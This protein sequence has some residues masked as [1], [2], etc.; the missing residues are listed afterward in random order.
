MRSSLSDA[1]HG[2]AS[3]ACETVYN[4]G[5]KMSPPLN[6]AERI[7]SFAVVTYIPAPLGKF[8]DQLRRDLEPASLAPRAHV[9]VLPPRALREGVTAADAWLQLE[10]MIPAFH[11]FPIRLG[12]IEIFPIT[13]VVY[14]SVNQGLT[15]LRVMHETLNTGAV[16]AQENFRYQ[17][18][19]T[20][21]QGLAPEQAM[22]IAASAQRLWNEFSG[23][24]FFSAETFTFV[25]NTQKNLWIDLGEVALAE[26][27]GVPIRKA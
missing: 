15:D 3:R 4:L 13:N 26:M 14:L 11:V 27:V 17:P 9:T 8:L 6:G 12:H 21:A 22:E 10:R 16:A 5:S 18:H 19:V 2:R 25:Q 7:N 23:P 1:S 24:R 20:L